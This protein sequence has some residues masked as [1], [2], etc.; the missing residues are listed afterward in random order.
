MSYEKLS[1]S[2]IDGGGA[3][4]AVDHLLEEVVKN[5]RDVNTDPMVARVVTLKITI[6]PTDSSRKEASI[7]Y[8]GSAKMAPD[9]PGSDHLLI[10]PSTGEAF[11][12]DMQQL[13]FDDETMDATRLVPKG[14]AK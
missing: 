13:T 11:V 10:S 4:S 12:P 14:D 6:K 8:Q 2:A 9:A 3:I 1:L 5:L 7:T